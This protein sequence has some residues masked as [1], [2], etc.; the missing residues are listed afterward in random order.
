MFSDYFNVLILKNFKNIILIYFQVKY[1]REDVMSDSC[2]TVV[3]STGSV[4][5]FMQ[6][7][8]LP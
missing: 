3:K 4:Q 5:W 6:V 2:V 7:K 1:Y 8:G